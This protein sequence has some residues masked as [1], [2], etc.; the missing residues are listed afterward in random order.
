MFYSDLVDGDQIILSEQEARHCTKVLRKKVGDKIPVLN[1][2]GSLFQT[3][4]EKSQGKEVLLRILEVEF[5]EDRDQPVIAFGLIKN[6]SRIEWM[7]EKLTEVGVSKIVPI[8]CQR[9]ER[10]SLKIERCEKIIVSAV[11]QSMQRYKPKIFAPV[12]LHQYLARPHD[13]S[14][15]IASY[16]SDCKQLKSVKPSKT[17]TQIL[18]GPEGD[19]TSEELS[20]A[21]EAGFQRVNLGKSRLRTETA[22]IVACTILQDYD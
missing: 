13:Q 12:S 21:L 8:L 20:L 7:L 4:I 17:G 11:K 22:A 2:A 14:K 19:F 5:E 1:G 16:C 10:K 18:I 6:M 15:Y 9:S 3:V